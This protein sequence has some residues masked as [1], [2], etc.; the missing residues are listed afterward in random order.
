[1][2]K[3]RL[4]RVAAMHRAWID[5]NMRREWRGENP[6]QDAGREVFAERR[7][8]T[9]SPYPWRELEG[10]RDEYDRRWEAEQGHQQIPGPGERGAPGT[11]SFTPVSPPPPTNRQ[12]NWTPL[13]G[14]FIP[15]QAIDD[16]FW[17]PNLP[18][19]MPPLPQ[20]RPAP[21]NVGIAPPAPPKPKPKPLPP[22]FVP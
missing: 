9:G 14:E 4:N 5:E 16:P 2:A 17:D 22:G 20:L 21:P 15:R 12:G 3:Q 6:G 10:A 1:M 8:R 19:A 13:G 11:P 7:R 18:R